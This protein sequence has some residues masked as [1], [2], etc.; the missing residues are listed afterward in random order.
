MYLSDAAEVKFE[1]LASGVSVEPS[2]L[3]HLLEANSERPLTPADYASTTGLILR[4]DRLVW[5]NAPIAEHNPNFV[6]SPTYILEHTADGMTLQGAARSAAAEVWAQPAYHGTAGPTGRPWN[7][8][9]VT[10]GD[11]ARLAPIG[12]CAMACKFCNIP[13]EDPYVTKPIELLLQSIDL[14]L[15]D[16]IQPARHLLISGGTPRATDV[17]YL[18]DVYRTVL[19]RFPG[20]EVD[21]M[22]APVDGLFDLDELAELGI[23]QLSVNLE[24]FDLDQARRLAPH[25]YRQ[26]RQ[27]YLDFISSATERLGAGTVRS[28]LMVGLETAGSTLNG[29]RAILDVGGVPVLSPFRPD[30][31]TPLRDEPPFSAEE[32]REVFLESSEMAAS[33]GS[34]LGPDCGPCSHNTMT[35]PAALEDSIVDGPRHVVRLI[36]Q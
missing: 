13:Y 27:H 9:I 24:I 34:V 28:M 35:L 15:N 23:H 18:R 3:A 5:V 33:Y 19:E 6:D 21:I 25:K 14:A 8:L 29:V 10:H 1:V 16:P 11:R 2:C 20:L 36:D 22:M 12:G 4:L 17:P 7:H 26:G 30:P 31:V 32:L